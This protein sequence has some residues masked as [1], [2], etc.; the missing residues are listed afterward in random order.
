MEWIGGAGSGR[1]ASAESIPAGTT[2]SENQPS[3]RGSLRISA[4][5][6]LKPPLIGS[7]VLMP[8]ASGV[9]NLRYVSI[10]SFSSWL[11]SQSIDLAI[12]SSWAIFSGEM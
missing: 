9:A 6:V 11:R 7:G 1:A 2:A 3:R 4:L 10:A 5:S 12:K 8:F